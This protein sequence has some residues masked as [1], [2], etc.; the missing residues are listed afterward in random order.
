MKRGLRSKS[1]RAVLCSG[2][3]VLTDENQACRHASKQKISAKKA[4]VDISTCQAL[5]QKD[6]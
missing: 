1:R 2:L 3:A 6:F 4:Y 5:Q